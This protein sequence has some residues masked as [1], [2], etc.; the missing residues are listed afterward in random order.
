MKFEDDEDNFICDDC[1]EEFPDDYNAGFEEEQVCSGC[2]NNRYLIW[3]ESPC[4]LCGKPMKIETKSYY[5]DPDSNS[6]H[7]S[8][9]N[10]LSDDEIEDKEWSCIDDY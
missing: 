10:K 1:G 2:A 5:Y 3:L 4:V 6:A 8:C 7:K 9:V